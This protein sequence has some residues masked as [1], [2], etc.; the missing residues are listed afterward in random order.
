MGIELEPLSGRE[1]HRDGSTLAK[2]RA[3]ARDLAHLQPEKNWRRGWESNPRVK[4]LQT[5]PLP[6]GYRAYCLYRIV[7]RGQNP[8]V[9]EPHLPRMYN[10]YT[11]SRATREEVQQEL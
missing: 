5:S 10:S 7:F 6:L 4:V 3:P 11:F 9:R 8:E 2:S 1:E